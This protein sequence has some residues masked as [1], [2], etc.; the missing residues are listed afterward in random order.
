MDFR[1]VLG[2]DFGQQ[3][4][5]AIIDELGAAANSTDELAQRIIGGAKV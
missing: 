3:D 1:E 4:D 2:L 5:I